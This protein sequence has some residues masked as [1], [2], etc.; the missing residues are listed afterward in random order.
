MPETILIINADDDLTMMKNIL[1]K[2]GYDIK[3]ATKGS[4]ALE[5]VREKAFD[6]ILLNIKMPALSGY[7]LLR[8]NRWIR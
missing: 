6:L 8:D 4:Q 3:T 5:L 2:E 1:D 7:D